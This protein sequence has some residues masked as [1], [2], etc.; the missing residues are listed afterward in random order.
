MRR[1]IEVKPNNF[2]RAYEI[3]VS[4]WSQYSLHEAA[5]I[6]REITAGG[7]ETPMTFRERERIMEEKGKKEKIFYVLGVVK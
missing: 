5:A 1:K 2:E 6:S 7:T 4:H 3:L